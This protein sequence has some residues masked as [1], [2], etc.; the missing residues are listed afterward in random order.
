MS[1]KDL[2][3]DVAAFYSDCFDDG[4]VLLMV[5]VDQARGQKK[6]AIELLKRYGGVCAGANHNDGNKSDSL[7]ARNGEPH[8]RRA[9]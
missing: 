3:G 9:L 1:L 4:A 7:L 6:V 5:R 8:G 2:I